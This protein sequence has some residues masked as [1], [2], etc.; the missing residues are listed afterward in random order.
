[1]PPIPTTEE[2]PD[3][4]PVITISNAS[5]PKEGPT[6]ESGPG[7]VPP[8]NFLEDSLVVSPSGVV[9]TNLLCHLAPD[10]DIDRLAGTRNSKVVGL[11]LSNLA[12]ALAWGGEVIKS[13]T[14]AQREAGDLRRSFDDVI[15]QFTQLETRLAEVEADR[16][17]EPR[18]AEVHL[19]ALV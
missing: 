2:R 9:A 17:E 8:L 12:A 19:A 1:M 18:V 13:L 3:L 7:R 4:T 6:K 14:R 10:R 15:E 11:F 16:A 5:S